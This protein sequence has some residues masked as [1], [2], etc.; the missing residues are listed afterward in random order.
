[1]D[2]PALSEAEHLHALS[3]LGRIN[4]F[5]GTASH[6]AAAIGRLAGAAP[7]SGRPLELVDV[8]CGGGDV[9]V[10]LARRLNGRLASGAEPDVSIV[11]LDMSGRAVMRARAHAAA[12]GIGSVRF[13]VRDVVAEGCPACDIAISS[14]FLHHL[15]DDLAI[16]VLRSLAAA[17]RI[18]VIVSDLLRSRLGLVLATLGTGVLST[19]RVAR[20]DGPL[21]VRAARTRSEYAALLDAAGLPG[22][23]IRRVWPERAL[24]S[25]RR[26][27]GVAG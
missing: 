3:A 27:D 25:W 9:T 17:A 24:I 23:S 6:L 14:L 10:S 8:A 12:A 19:S 21:S 26:A 16:D 13:A 18:G 2:D 11:G 22:A 5:S 15:D 4:A 20:I 7:V 1:M